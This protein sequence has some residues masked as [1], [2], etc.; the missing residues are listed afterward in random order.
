MYPNWL[1][2]LTSQGDVPNFK[3]GDIFLGESEET[4]VHHLGYFFGDADM[5]D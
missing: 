2:I 5:K 1:V 3:I 4:L